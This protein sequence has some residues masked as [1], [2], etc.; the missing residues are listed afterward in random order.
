MFVV[1]SSK[2][3]SD[4]MREKDETYCGSEHLLIVIEKIFVRILE[5]PLLYESDNKV[6][7]VYAS[8]SKQKLYTFFTINSH[9][10]RIK[11]SLFGIN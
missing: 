7:E 5:K 11:M 2:E 8:S 1:K 4:Q 3:I 10:I 6:C 9:F